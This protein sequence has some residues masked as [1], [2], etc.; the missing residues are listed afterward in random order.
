MLTA[1]RIASVGRTSCV[2]APLWEQ[3]Q[4][5][6]AAEMGDLLVSMAVAADQWRQRGA[7]AVPVEERDAW[8]AQY[9]ELL[10]SGFAVQPLPKAEQ[11]P[12]RGGRAEQVLAFLDD[13]SIPFT[14]DVVAYCT[15]SAWLACVVRR[16]W[17]LFVGWRKQGNPTAIGLIHGNAT[18]SPPIPDRLWADSIGVCGFTG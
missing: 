6:W 18:S 14:N 16:V 17:S 4:Q 11:V 9:F 1:V 10:G 15:P 12:K 3:E 13:L 5:P 2:I 7:A 8:V